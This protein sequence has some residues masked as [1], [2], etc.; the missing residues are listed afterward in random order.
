[1]FENPG[2][3]ARRGDIQGLRALAVLAV[4]LFHVDFAYLPGGFLGVDVFFVVSGF[5]ITGIIMRDVHGRKITIWEFYLRRIRRLLPASVFTIAITLFACAVIFSTTDQ[6]ALAESSLYA[7]FSV[8]N[9]LFWSQ[10]GYFDEAAHLKPLL[11][12]WSLAVEEQFYLVWPWLLLG[13][14]FFGRR[15]AFAAIVIVGVASV[16]A[17]EWWVSDH[18]DAVFFLTPFR[19]FEF[20]AGG[21]LAFSRPLRGGIASVAFAVGLC[22]MLWSFVVLDPEIPMPGLFSLIP[23]AGVVLCLAGGVGR[24]SKVLD[25]PPMRKIGN[26]S[27]SL[28]LVHWPIIV[29][30]K[31][32]NGPDLVFGQQVV[33]LALSLAAGYGLYSLVETPLRSAEFWKEGASRK[34]VLATV[35]AAGAVAASVNAWATN[36]WDWRVPQELRA[37]TADARTMRKTRAVFNKK[38]LRDLNVPLEEY[39]I[40]IIGDSHSQDLMIGLYQVGVRDMRRVS[41]SYRCQFYVGERVLTREGPGAR[42]AEKRR[43][44]K[45]NASVKR[46]IKSKLL[47]G[48]DV[49][50]IAPRWKMETIAH[51]P[52]M[53]EAIRK[54]TDA[55]IIVFG[56]T[57]EFEPSLPTAVERAG[58]TIGIDTLVARFERPTPRE[59]DT[60]LRAVVK[61]AGAVYVSKLDVL[62]G[63]EPC[64][65]FVPGTKSLLAF[66]YGH[67]TQP[68][69]RYFA[70]QLFEKRPDIKALLLQ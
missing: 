6:M 59:I 21:A 17:A 60:H 61:D 18:P 14:V 34:A 30:F 42:K 16:F 32:F 10:A 46:A 11:H 37:A 5:L 57:V 50:A 63:D 66:D 36:G 29:L 13:A 56:P 22:I 38:M 53:I 33:L 52:E 47:P 49:V 2:K 23:V 7:L 24:A 39:R 25:N 35:V 28:Y 27:Y 40:A 19:A 1:M 69:A 58:S 65:V 20:A 70:E 45:C 67:W 26:M 12:T 43:T 54:R 68:G 31:Y 15:V 48:A 3:S 64:P 41:V 51:V 55:N 44:E 62:C 4:L 8:S 9:F